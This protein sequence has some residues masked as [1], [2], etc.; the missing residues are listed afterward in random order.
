M[1]YQSRSGS[2]RRKASNANKVVLLWRRAAPLPN[3]SSMQALGYLT[4]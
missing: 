1:T 2:Q 4:P 3:G